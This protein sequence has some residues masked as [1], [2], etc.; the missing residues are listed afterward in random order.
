MIELLHCLAQRL[1]KEA[2]HHQIIF[3]R[4]KVT[5]FAKESPHNVG[6]SATFVEAMGS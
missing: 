1:I 2:L 4:S 5:T 6:G 3:L